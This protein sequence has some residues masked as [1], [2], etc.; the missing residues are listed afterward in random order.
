MLEYIAQEPTV[1]EEITS[2]LSPAALHW[3]EE[4]MALLQAD[5]TVTGDTA[6]FEMA[7]ILF[8]LGAVGEV[9]LIGRGAG[10]ILPR[11]STLNV[12]VIATL[13]D[14]IAYMGQWRRLTREEAAEQVALRDRRRA[15]Y[16]RTHYHT[17][18]AD[19]YQYDLVLNTT[20]LGEELSADL[21]VHAARTRTA[22]LLVDASS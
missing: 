16:I 6:L 7:R 13:E 3:V 17:D 19:V 20:L 4:Q 1:R 22:A 11:H 8:S 21:L 14:R 18:S 10:C 5:D 12:R 2:N 15:D 9:L